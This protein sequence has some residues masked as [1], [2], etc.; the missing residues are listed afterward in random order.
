MLGVSGSVQARVSE[1]KHAFTVG[2]VYE[3]ANS[4]LYF[5]GKITTYMK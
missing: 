1:G 3:I 4:G 2:L 5:M